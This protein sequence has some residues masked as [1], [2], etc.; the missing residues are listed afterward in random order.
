[1]RVLGPLLGPI[2]RSG[3]KKDLQKLRALLEADP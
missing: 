3:L 2:A 1:M